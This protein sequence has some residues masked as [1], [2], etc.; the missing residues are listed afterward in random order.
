MAYNSYKEDEKSSN[1]G[2]MKTLL[3]L[4]KY[5]FVYKWVILLVLALMGYGVAVSLI[6]PLIL[7]SAIDDYGT[8]FSNISNLL[9]YMPNYVKIDRSL[10]ENIQDKPRIQK[11]VAGIIEF[12]HENGYFALAEGV[13][14][15]CDDECFHNGCKISVGGG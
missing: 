1:V 7:E 13:A 2:K 3:R 4:L 15:A 10:I 14:V 6:N 12:V 8:G 11:L 5:L 9:R